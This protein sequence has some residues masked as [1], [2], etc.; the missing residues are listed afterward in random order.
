VKNASRKTA[1][2]KT[3]I[4]ALLATTA[5]ALSG[6]QQKM[7][8]R[9]RVLPD[10]AVSVLPGGTSA[11]AP[12]AGTVRF[13]RENPDEAGDSPLTKLARLRR[14]KVEFETFCTPCHG[15]A[16]YGNGRVV[17]RGFTAPPSFHSDRLRAAPDAHFDTVIEKGYGAMPS[18]GSRI[19]PSERPGLI[20]YIRALQRSQHAEVGRLPS[21]DRDALDRLPPKEAR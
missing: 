18:Y 17:Q 15:I 10:S 20:G 3:F 8:T 13:R 1:R 5:L 14:G 7:G 6:C 21:E 11:M 2:A 16:G 4:P 9:G 12:V 19:P